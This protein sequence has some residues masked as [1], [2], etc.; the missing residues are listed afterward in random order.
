MILKE[1]IMKKTLTLILSMLMILSVCLTGCN[2]SG[3]AK[4]ADELFF[5]NPSS[6]LLTNLLKDMGFEN[7]EDTNASDKNSKANLSFDISKL[8]V[9]GMD[10]I[11]GPMSFKMDMITTPD[12]SSSSGAIEYTYLTDSLKA[13][14]AGGADGGKAYVK[15]DG[16]TEKYIDVEAFSGLMGGASPMPTA[17]EASNNVTINPSAS[18]LEELQKAIF[19][20]FD[21]S[22]ITES[23]KE[24]TVNDIKT[25][26]RAIEYTV[27]GAEFKA[28]FEKLVNAV[29]DS[30]LVK[31]SIANSGTQ[32][33]EPD[34]SKIKFDDNDKLSIVYY[35]DVNTCKGCNI[36]FNMTGESIKMSLESKEASDKKG[37]YADINCSITVPADE[38]GSVAQTV[39]ITGNY[40]NEKGKFDAKLTLDPGTG[41]KVDVTVKGE[42]ADKDGTK[43][44]EMTLSIGSGGMSFNIPV[45]VTVK[46]STKEKIDCTISSTVSIPSAAEIAF[47]MGIKGEYTD[48]APATVSADDISDTASL[49]EADLAKLMDKISKT[50]ELIQNLGMGGAEPSPDDGG[51]I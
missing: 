32:L 38:A 37:D 21:K 39:A 11:E 26:V 1:K 29:L 27:T 50:I 2:G 17:A 3:K 8:N 51:D 42:V 15:L 49:G 16:I 35:F 28:V 31:D 12:G 46:E 9:G 13:L 36:E 22:K 34:F 47:S 30:K 19:A 20:C 6:E 33:P 45:T 41:V 24:I 25:K 4:P 23:K 43:T 40:K 7:E 18:D 14:I 10:V 44:T 48:E 5:S